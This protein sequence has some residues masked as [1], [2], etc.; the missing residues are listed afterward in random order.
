MS[1]LTIT[2][3]G[4]T[5]TT[6]SDTSLNKAAIIRVTPT[7]TE[8]AAY[9][10]GDV[11]FTATEIPKAVRTK[12]GISRIV[13]AY[14]I[15]QDVDTYGF[16]MILTEKSTAIGTIHATANISDGDFE[17]IGF[18]GALAVKSNVAVVADLDNVNI[19]NATALGAVAQDHSIL[20][21]AESDSTSVYVSG[22]L[23]S[24]TPTFAVV[25]D[26]DMVFHIEYLS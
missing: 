20:I 7:L 4:S 6:T 8:D 18:C 14:V 21:Q 2:H 23:T 22:I 9:A 1:D 13:G 26:I 25:D 5:V 3:A 16:D 11:L 19:M 10:D 12:G 17:A 24:G 15:D